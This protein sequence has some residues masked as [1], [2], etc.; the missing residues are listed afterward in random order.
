MRIS[1]QVPALPW[2]VAT[3]SLVTL[4]ASADDYRE[5]F[6]KGEKPDKMSKFL[7]NWTSGRHDYEFRI[8]GSLIIRK[9]E[10]VA[11]RA[12][13]VVSSDPAVVFV[14]FDPKRWSTEYNR[15]ELHKGQI[16]IP[17]GDTWAE[18]KRVPDPT[19]TAQESKSK[20]IEKPKP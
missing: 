10:K 7:G 19:P 8:D 11:E 12:S 2:M 15:L 14:K 17:L 6:S 5:Q 3:L 18:L 1:K 4:S 9:D 13:W 16:I 20:D